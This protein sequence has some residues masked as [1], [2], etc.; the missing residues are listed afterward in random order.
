V[1]VQYNTAL[2]SEKLALAIASA[3]AESAK[4]I[5]GGADQKLCK[6]STLTETDKEKLNQFENGGNADVTVTL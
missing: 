2:Y 1:N 5:I 4:S 3:I 6:L